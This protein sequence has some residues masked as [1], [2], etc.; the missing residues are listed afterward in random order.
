[1][2]DATLHTGVGAMPDAFGAADDLPMESPEDWDPTLADV[3]LLG[4]EF[5]DDGE[6]VD[7]ASRAA[8]LCDPRL[9]ARQLGALG[10]A[11]A[12]IWLRERSWLILDANWRSRHGELDVVA[13]TP[14]RTIVFVEVKTRR[15]ALYGAP[16][17]AVGAAKQANLRRAATQWLAER[18]ARLPHAGVRFDVL[19][20]RVGRDGVDVRHIPEAF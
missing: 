16:E 10:E 19:A 14:H 7:F 20:L 2:N 12:R 18:G 17:E 8:R 13:M 4:D 6:R 1:M 5:A 9:T 15:T 11:L 3:D